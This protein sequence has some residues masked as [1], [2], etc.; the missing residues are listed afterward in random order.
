MT[1]ESLR[2]E[3]RDHVA[4]ITLDRPD[5]YNALDLTLGRELF[6]ATLE[7]DE[8]S[9]RTKIGFRHRHACPASSD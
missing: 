8:D 6:H 9:Q 1:Y 7:V 3:R 5:A 2:L 4:T